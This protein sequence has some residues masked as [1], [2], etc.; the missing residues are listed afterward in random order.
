MWQ[1][2]L[3]LWLWAGTIVG[4]L[5]FSPQTGVCGEENES[6]KV[7]RDDESTAKSR[8]A[9][10][11]E[12]KPPMKSF[13]PERLSARGTLFPVE[14]T[15]VDHLSPTQRERYAQL[16]H[17]LIDLAIPADSDA[18]R[19]ASS[20]N[21]VR[22]AYDQASTLGGADPR[23]LW[24]HSLVLVSQGETP[25]ALRVLDELI[26]IAPEFQIVP[27]LERASLDLERGEVSKSLESARQVVRYWPKQPA[28]VETRSTRQVQAKWLGQALGYLAAAEDAPE[29]DLEELRDKVSSSWPESDRRDLELE[30][31]RVRV[32]LR[33]S[34]TT[35][36]ELWERQQSELLARKEELRESIRVSQ[37]RERRMQEEIWREKQPW[38]QSRN[39]VLA[40][41]KVHN[42]HLW[43]LESEAKQ[44]QARRQWVLNQG[45]RP[46]L[47]TLV[48]SSPVDQFGVRPFPRN[49]WQRSSRSR[50]REE[51]RSSRSGWSSGGNW[52]VMTDIP[53]HLQVEAELNR[54][55]ERM[56]AL[57]QSAEP[58]FQQV[59]AGKVKR[60]EVEGELRG[61][62][63]PLKR[64]LDRVRL[65]RQAMQRELKSL[66]EESRSKQ[67]T[68]P[69]DS[70]RNWRTVSEQDL[71]RELQLWWR[72]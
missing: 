30:F 24:A 55:D 5:W 38:E 50:D 69:S 33:K 61:N 72:E 8:V 25:A 47:S 7:S 66:A 60:Q 13:I 17:K 49:S 39:I 1:S 36:V 71:L 64:D 51:P 16:V 21:R 65:D 59:A 42:E 18:N 63:T 70:F 57:R 62:V 32:A 29:A 46:T 54:I 37:D 34:R 27:L 15:A 23:L 11:A 9:N 3:G 19:S 35:Q 28:G 12:T 41:L 14:A 68:T 48:V 10:D 53:R 31:E 4:G 22:K 67:P 45:L 52:S 44:L 6:G 58:V 56:T 2:T 40:E 43:R 20:R 26:R